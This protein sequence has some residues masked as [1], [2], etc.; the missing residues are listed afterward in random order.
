MNGIPSTTYHFST[1]EWDEKLGLYYFGARCYSPEIGRWGLQDP[2]GA[3]GIVKPPPPTVDIGIC[4]FRS[5]P[6]WLIGVLP[7]NFS[8]SMYHYWMHVLPTNQRVDLMYGL[9]TVKKFDYS[10]KLDPSAKWPTKWEQSPHR[11]NALTGATCDCTS[12]R[13]YTTASKQCCRES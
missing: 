6:A 10:G 11:T 5:G 1:K 4:V 13:A 8:T 12:L 7:P 9:Q 2:S 3:H